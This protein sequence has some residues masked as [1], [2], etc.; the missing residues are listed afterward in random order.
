MYTIYKALE[1]GTVER[2]S[3]SVPEGHHAAALLMKLTTNYYHTQNGYWP[4]WFVVYEPT[5]EDT[6]CE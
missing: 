4:L 5:T 2:S 6:Y 1:D 3:T